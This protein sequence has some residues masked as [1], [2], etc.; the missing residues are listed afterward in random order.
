MKSNYVLITAIKSPTRPEKSLGYEYSIE[1]WKR[2]CASNKCELRVLDE[3]LFDMS[4]MSPIYFR[5]YWHELLKNEEFDQVAL[6]DC[7]TVVHP[8]CPN[9][10]E[11]TDHQFSAV[12]NDGDYDWIIR[13]IE[14]YQYEFP[15]YFTKSFDIWKYFNTGFMVTN[16]KFIPF[17]EGLVEFYWNN[18]S[19]IRQV[20]GKYGCGTDQPLSNLFTNE[21]D[22]YVRLLDYK[23]NIQDISRKN[24]LDDRMIF[25][26]IEGIYHFN[27]VS[28]GC[29]VVQGWM[30]K[31]YNYLYND[32]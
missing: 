12:H 21:K 5:H 31:T 7:D 25:T 3:P 15:E 9:F 27:A 26:K 16:E 28:G 24:V 11:L 8:N 18:A 14:N 19:K 22:I 30:E 29:E 10:F 2:W 6:I 32:Q 4:L 17:H 20:Q 13:S 23:F 1:S